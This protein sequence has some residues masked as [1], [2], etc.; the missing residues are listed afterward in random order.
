M[1]IHYIG[2]STVAFNSIQTYPQTGMSQGLSWYVKPSVHIHSYAKNGRSTKSFLAEGRFEAVKGNMGPGD[3]LL[4]QFG[5][6][7]EKPDPAR[8]TDPSTTF[9]ENLRIF[10]EGAKEAGALP[11]LLTPIARRL[12]DETG[13]FRPGSHGAYPQA[14]RD[15]GKRENVPVIDLTA[16]TETFLAELGDEASKPLFVWPVDNTHLKV[17]GAIRMAGFVAE[18]LRELGSPYSHVL[19]SEE[20]GAG[21][22]S[23]NAD[24]L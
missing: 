22:L 10:I 2:D 20:D 11:I 15:T 23:P 9:P 19:A 3:L 21:G 17:E 4:I 8:G 24:V 1:T 14:T 13:A 5:H 12:F 7:D 18:G 6:N 16:Q